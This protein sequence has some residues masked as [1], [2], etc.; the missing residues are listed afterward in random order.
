MPDY[1][2]HQKKIIN[3]YYD[4]RDEIMLTRLQEIVTDLV[5]ADTPAQRKRLWSRASKA[6]DA[7]KVPRE[8]RD[9][10]IARDDP[11]FL[12]RK[13]RTWLGEAKKGSKTTG[14]GQP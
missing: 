13:V 6:M 2:S 10:I 9:R 3:R 4:N 12:A 5:L 7:L 8:Q 14:P 1:T 11:E